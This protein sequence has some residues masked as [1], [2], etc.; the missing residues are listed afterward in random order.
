MQTSDDGQASGTPVQALASD[1]KILKPQEAQSPSQQASE[2]TRPLTSLQASQSL[3]HNGIKAQSPAPAPLMASSSLPR[4]PDA[5]LYISPKVEADF[6]YS[7]I[8]YLI[9]Q[10]F[11]VSRFDDEHCFDPHDVILLAPTQQVQGYPRSHAVTSKRALWDFMKLQ[12]KGT[13]L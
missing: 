10:G 1:E 4:R 11:T 2:D 6:L 8:A 12:F 3:S 9:R 7:F 5:D 13:K